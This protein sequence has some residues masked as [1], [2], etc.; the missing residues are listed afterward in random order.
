MPK[1]TNPPGRLRCSARYDD[2]R[3]CQHVGIDGVHRGQHAAK[4]SPGVRWGTPKKPWRPP[5][6]LKPA[7]VRPFRDPGAPL[8]ES[9]G[10]LVLALNLTPGAGRVLDVLVAHLTANA[11]AMAETGQEWGWFVGHGDAVEA[12]SEARESLA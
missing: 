5:D 6:I 11:R 2:G 8:P 1:A 12:I 7:R 9:P 4:G 10:P 3:R